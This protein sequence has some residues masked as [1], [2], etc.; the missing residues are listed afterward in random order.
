VYLVNGI[1]NYTYK[2][3]QYN[4]GENRMK[5]L[6]LFFAIVAT[7]TAVLSPAL[8]SDVVPINLIPGSTISPLPNGF[9]SSDLI[10]ETLLFDQSES[11]SFADGLTG[12]LRDRVIKYSD[13][14]S[15]IH[16]GLYFDYEVQLSS[17]SIAAITIS[18]YST[19]ET[20]FETFVKVCGISGCGGSGANGIAPTSVSR[21]ADGNE[22]AFDFGNILMAGQHSANLQIFSS[23][24]LF[25]DPV[26]LLTDSSGNSFSINVVG[27]RAIPEPSTWAL[28]LLGFAGL[29]FLGYRAP[30]KSAAIT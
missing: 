17:G 16:P 21:S 30:R 5:T 22:I 11:F 2:M 13:V 20:T 9:S 6:C 1:G 7:L 3:A 8:A 24:S 18:G 28:M 4:V 19:P 14:P 29:G 10:P 26:A 27:P 23:A 12:V 15:A 25:Q